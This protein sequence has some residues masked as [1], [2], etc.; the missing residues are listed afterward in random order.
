M[1]MDHDYIAHGSIVF[2]ARLGLQGSAD[3]LGRCPH[4]RRAMGDGLEDYRA[5]S[6]LSTVTDGYVPQDRCAGTDQHIPPHLGMAVLA[7]ALAS[8]AQGNAVQEGA[9]ISDDGS[10]SDD[11]AGRVV[12]HD[13]L[14]D[15]G[16]RV[17]VNPE[18]GRRLAL[19]PEGNE[20]GHLAGYAGRLAPSPSGGPVQ[21]ECRESFLRSDRARNAR[22][23][24]CEKVKT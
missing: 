12:Q 6:D 10:L 21:N 16:G 9:A 5:C 22:Y 3:D 20:A 14:A 17:D 15:G 24:M 13:G 1:K 11:D 18:R 2:T 4:G 7:L 8:T 19:Q 23:L